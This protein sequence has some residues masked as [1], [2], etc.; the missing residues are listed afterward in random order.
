M[1]ALDG[2]DVGAALKRAETNVALL[3]PYARA[4][5]PILALQPTC[6]LLL[7]QDYPTLI[8]SEESALV[9]AQTKDITQYLAD[10]MKRGKLKRDFQSSPGAVTYHLSCHTKAQG[11][12][13]AAKDLLESIDG[14]QV[15][16]VDRCA[17]I[18]GTWGLKAAYYD[19][20]IQV[21][22]KLTERFLDRH[23][24]KACSDCALAGLQI[25][26][27]TDESPVHPVEIL[28]RAYG[29]IGG[30]GRETT[31]AG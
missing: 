17:G 27:A 26:T 28:A 13:R 5:K 29:L 16:L 20:A 25:E 23:D 6:A 11:L 4:K 22:A 18:D 7:K 12:K 3:A 9:A 14:C 1:P 10:A 31:G 15:E 30:T 8:E 21:S 19:E 2:G 24:V